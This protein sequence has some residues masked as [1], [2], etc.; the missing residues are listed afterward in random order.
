MKRFRSSTGPKFT[1]SFTKAPSTQ[2]CQKC[3]QY[4]HYTYECKG[5]RV[6]NARPTRTQQLHKPTKRIQVEV[7][8]EF[9]SK[10]GLAAKILK[11][12]EEERQRKKEEKDKKRNKK[13]RRRRQCIVFIFR[14]ITRTKLEQEQQHQQSILQLV[15]FVAIVVQLA[16]EIAFAHFSS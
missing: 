12:K 3:L 5:G 1:S 15:S 7:P 10:K 14:I 6:Y 13:K 9:L 2:Q 16:L 8:E 11:E 4:G